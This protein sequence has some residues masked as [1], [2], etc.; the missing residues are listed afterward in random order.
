MA[1]IQRKAKPLNKKPVLFFQCPENE[2]A[3][4]IYDYVN[5]I[6][7][8]SGKVLL[9]HTDS[10]GEVKKQIYPKQESL[11]RRLMSQTRRKIPMRQ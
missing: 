10:T 9:I 3:D 4:E 7:D 2:E 11:Q 6:P 8:T 1:R 5:S